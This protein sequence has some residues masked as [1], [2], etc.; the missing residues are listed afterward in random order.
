MVLAALA[1]GLDPS[2]A[3]RVFGYRQ[4]T[5]T[6]W[7]S[8]AGGH[9]QTLHERFFRTLHLPYLQL[10]ELRTRLRCAKRVLWLWLV[11]D[12]CTKILPVLQLGPRT[13]PMAHRVIHSLRQLLAPG[14]IPVFTSDGLN[15]YFYALTAHF[16]HWLQMGRRGLY[17]LLGT[18]V[19]KNHNKSKRASLHCS[20]CRKNSN[21][22]SRRSSPW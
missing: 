5:I 6:T 14:C 21:A 8:R 4:A 20:S 13:Q 18:S 17:W 12:P 16:G 1:E 3:E 19:Q 7:L 11:I 15:V 10:D 9:A 22:S 2:A